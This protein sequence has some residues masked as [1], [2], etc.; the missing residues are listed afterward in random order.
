MATKTKL[1]FVWTVTGIAATAFLANWVGGRFLAYPFL[2][3]WGSAL[4]GPIYRDF[5]L[6]VLYAASLYTLYALW[7]VYPK[8]VMGG[9]LTFIGTIRLPD[10]AALMF[11]SGGSCG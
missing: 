6:L 10:V 5:A 1:T 3:C 7:I 8:G 4:L 2:Y 9:V 11:L